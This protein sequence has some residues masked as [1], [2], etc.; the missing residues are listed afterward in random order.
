MR[1]YHFHQANPT[2]L[3]A[4]LLHWANWSSNQINGLKKNGFPYPNLF[5]VTLEIVAKPGGEIIL[6]AGTCR[7]NLGQNL[8]L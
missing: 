4:H 5:G 3:L 1:K 8:P 7:M 6:G 2:V